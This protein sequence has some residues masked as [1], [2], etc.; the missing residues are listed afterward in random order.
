MERTSSTNVFRI[1]KS[2]DAATQ[3]SAQI[4]PA[5]FPVILIFNTKKTEKIAK[6]VKEDTTIIHRP[7]SIL[8]EFS[9]ANSLILC[10]KFNEFGHYFNEFKLS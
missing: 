2:A 6:I 3:N 10:S 1:Q 9:I 4:I 7:M 8:R 5:S